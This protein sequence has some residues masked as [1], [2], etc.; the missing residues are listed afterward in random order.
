[1]QFPPSA[2]SA[3]DVAM[4]HAL[5]LLVLVACSS[6]RTNQLP[7]EA[8]G[9]D[10]YAKAGIAIDKPWVADDFTN[11][12]TVL[13]RVT[14]GHRE[15]L[16]R[17]KGPKSGPVFDRLLVPV[18]MGDAVTLADSFPVHVQRY[19]A[20]NAIA[21]L[22][23]EN[24]MAVP[25]R[26][27]IELMGAL[28]AEANVLASRA[29]E[30]LA[31]FGPDDPNREV[32]QAGLAKM[33]SGYGMMVL[34]GLM[35]A[36]DTRVPEADRIAL[37]QH[38]TTAMPVLFPFAPADTQKL[39]RDQAAKLVDGLPKGAVRDAVVAAQKAIP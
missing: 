15:R 7:A 18:A 21:K 11:A 16:P 36:G 14:T 6:S 22:Y 25:T 3:Y 12:A 30:L 4:K 33:K 10:D 34:G 28:L 13:A 23:V 5:A 20:L 19:E 26:E 17:Y 39:I 27:W 24:E 38:V 31:S 32:R 37:V 29:D 9:V 1:M 35:V 2:F 8:W